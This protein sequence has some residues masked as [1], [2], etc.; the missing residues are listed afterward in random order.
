MVDATLADHEPHGPAAEEQDRILARVEAGEIVATRLGMAPSRF[1]DQP[2]DESVLDHQVG[3]GVYGVNPFRCLAVSAAVDHA[4]LSAAVSRL[5]NI[6]RLRP[7]AA[8]RMALRTGY[9][10]HLGDSHGFDA[11]DALADPRWRILCELFW[12]HVSVTEMESLRNAGSLA[13]REAVAM[14]LKAAHG[15]AGRELLLAKHAVAVACHNRALSWEL[16]YATGHFD[17]RMGYWTR[18]LQLW[19]EVIDSDDFWQYLCE[20]AES[21][22]DP[23]LQPADVAVLRQRAPGLILG[24]NRL[25]ARAYARHGDNEA[26]ARQLTAIARS[27]FPAPARNEALISAVQLLVSNRLEPLILRAETPDE[28]AEQGSTARIPRQRFAELYEPLVHEAVRIRDYL[29]HDMRCSAELVA[30]ARFDHFCE[31][32]VKGINDRIDYSDDHRLRSILYGIQVAQRL[33]QLPISDS[34]QRKIER[35][36]RHDTE[37][38]YR[39]MGDLPEG[40]QAGDCWFIPGEPADPDA[41]LELSVYKITE[42]NAV[43][44]RWTTR[45]VLVPRS[46]LASAV[47]RGDAKARETLAKR[48]GDPVAVRLREQIAHLEHRAAT[49]A[50][51][52][53]A[54]RQQRHAEAEGRHARILDAYERN[55]R[56]S[57]EAARTLVARYD[58][59]LRTRVAAEQK[60]CDDACAA[61]AAQHAPAIDQ[62]RAE[63]EECTVTFRGFTGF[64][65]FEL[66]GTGIALPAMLVFTY[67]GMRGAGFS[68]PAMLIAALMTAAVFGGG[69]GAVLRRFL[70]KRLGMPLERL[71][72]A[73]DAE[74]APLRLQA[75]TA[76]EQVRRTNLAA[77]EPYRRTVAQ[78]EAKRKELSDQRQYELAAIDS[79]AAEATRLAQQNTHRKL[80][81]L[82]GALEGRTTAK[83]EAARY[84]FPPYRY[85]RSNG[86]SDGEKPSDSEVKRQMEREAQRFFENLSYGE[87][88]TLAYVKN[89][90]SDEQFSQILA[91]LATASSSERRE[92][93]RQLESLAMLGRIRQ[94]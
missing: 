50:Q 40:F 3:A 14:L 83:P 33:L 67:L 34:Q 93:F 87:R 79:E 27:G 12:P 59:D 72:A 26:C 9:D 70:V 38:L 73:R 20:R 46:R 15:L 74:T 2:L 4:G 43:N 94:Y 92:L 44:C 37:I 91:R 88:E 68:T 36:I 86:Y 47:H 17:G 58:A 69:L 45:K 8:R 61:V 48:A 71:T 76:I 65:R 29:L 85:C 53:E 77:S 41:S 90:V 89:V 60:K 7:D 80:A 81:E 82:R 23:R 39:E 32:V 21:Y 24:F 13:S 42:I 11:V 30:S 10:G 49:E 51:P 56:Q 75:K 57:E 16:A 84:D 52:I 63:F 18:A 1:F 54:S 5:R 6:A 78:I 31:L 35:N 25:L 62:A 28:A 22:D 66:A 19:N 55:I 64:V